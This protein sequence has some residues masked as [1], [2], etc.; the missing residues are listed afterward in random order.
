MIGAAIRGQQHLVLAALHPATVR[1]AA[2]AYHPNGDSW[3]RR[4]R[5]AGIASRTC[6]TG[7][8]LIAFRSARTT[9]AAASQQARQ[10]NCNDGLKSMHPSQSHPPYKGRFVPAEAFR[11]E[12]R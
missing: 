4:P 1:I 9:R 8:S 3:S 6:R 7:R 11:R 2:R 12:R 10:R 5:R